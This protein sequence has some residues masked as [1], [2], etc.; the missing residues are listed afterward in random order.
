MQA[1]YSYAQIGRNVAL[2]A[3]SV[4]FSLVLCEIILRVF[5]AYPPPPHPLVPSRPDLYQADDRVGYRLWPSMT[6]CLRYPA[7]SPEI[8]PIVSNTDGFRNLREYGESDTRRR[9]LVIGDSFVFGLGVR[10]RERV[11]EVIESIEPSW[12]VDNLGMTGWGID[13]MIRALEHLGRKARPDIVV[14]A[15]YTDDFRRLLPDFAGVGYEI[16]KYALRGGQLVSVPYP[17]ARGWR[18]L[19]LVRFAHQFYWNQIADR[20]RYDLNEA[21]LDRFVD[22]ARDIGSQPVVV[23]LPGMADTDEDKARRRF[24]RDWGN[25]RRVPYLDLTDAIHGRG[26][27]KLFIDRNWHWNAAGHRVAAEEI[28]G[29]LHVKVI[30]AR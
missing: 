11:T 18:R 19:R 15:V 9:I 20:N 8:L 13:L 14:L 16:P 27:E 1:G 21:L 4:A 17:S 10:E 25:G 23:F 2:I 29:F 12:R 26:G 24:L 3:A 30:P 22:I 7:D 6:T 28:Y 5:N